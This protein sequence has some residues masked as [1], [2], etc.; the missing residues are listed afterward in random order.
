MPHLRVRDAEASEG[1]L[2]EI[3]DGDD[4]VDRKHPEQSFQNWCT[5]KKLTGGR[6]AIRKRISAIE[7]MKRKRVPQKRQRIDVLDRRP[8]HRR[9]GFCRSLR[10]RRCFAKS[11]IFAQETAVDAA[12]H[13]LFARERDSCQAP[14]AI[15]WRLADEKHPRRSDLFEIQTQI[16]AA[17]RVSLLIVRAI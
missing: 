3:A 2:G 4:A 5:E 13:D 10:A 6:E 15:T 1:A 8:H 16:V 9:A 11:A 14:A 17:D 7:R 12:Q